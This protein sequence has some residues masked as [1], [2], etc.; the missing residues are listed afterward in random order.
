[1][2]RSALLVADLLLLAQSVPYWSLTLH[3]SPLTA[4]LN[5]VSTELPSGNVT[6]GIC[7]LFLPS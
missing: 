7:S 3:A 5:G 4:D 6:L 2:V 1:M